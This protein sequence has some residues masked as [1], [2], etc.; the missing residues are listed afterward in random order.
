MGI[1]RSLIVDLKA[2]TA[3]FQSGMDKA[4]K[5]VGGFFVVQNKMGGIDFAK[6]FKSFGSTAGIAGMVATISSVAQGIATARNEGDGWF[7]SIVQGIPVVGDLAKQWK[8]V[9]D[10]VADLTKEQ[11]KQEE[12][13]ANYNKSIRDLANA[14]K[15]A[16]KSFAEMGK[17]SMQNA[18]LSFASDDNKPRL[19]AEFDYENKRQQIL[20]K[21]KADLQKLADIK[22][23]ATADTRGMEQSVA[24][25]SVQRAVGNYEKGK[26]E[27]EK[28]AKI[29]LQNLEYE[30]KGAV[31]AQDRSEFEKKLAEQQKEAEAT[32]KK[33]LDFTEQLNE[34]LRSVSL[35]E[36][37]QLE[38]QA[39]QMSAN[40]TELEKNLA[41]IQSIADAERKRT[42]QKEKDETG[43]RLADWEQNA[44]KSMAS[45]EKKALQSAF[46]LQYLS[47]QGKVSAQDYMS[48]Y[49]DIKNALINEYKTP[50]AKSM[51]NLM[52][53][54][55]YQSK[56]RGGKKAEDLL[57]KIF[58]RIDKALPRMS[59]EQVGKVLMEG[60]DIPS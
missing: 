33:Q 26:A 51:G 46:Q 19:Q 39:Q 57:E 38:Y 8:G 14:A 35:T 11:K 6:T 50:D 2:N 28:Q 16:A 15:D 58:Y 52:S 44:A 40:R 29:A 48:Q 25:M 59:K 42:E 53:A 23:K 32:R 45:P 56:T 49:K 55:Y 60:A 13:W 24:G 5:S 21:Q 3:A 7:A 10:T 1:I 9:L 17:Q 37:Q 43:K 27:V 47:S 20:E 4:A 36:Q 30:K 54:E 12:A 31:Y 41:L 18:R 22:N 34:K